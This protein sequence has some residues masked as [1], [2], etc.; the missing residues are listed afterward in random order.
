MNFKLYLKR[1]EHI[2]QLKNKILKYK[3]LIENK[4]D[5]KKDS[6][7]KIKHLD[8][9]IK[10]RREKITA[11]YTALKEDYNLIV[12]Q[13]NEMTKI[14]GI[15]GKTI[16]TIMQDL[17]EHIP[18]N[19]STQNYYYKVVK[20]DISDLKDISVNSEIIAGAILISYVEMQK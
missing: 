15:E 3:K 16:D 12:T 9:R 5:N 8:D 19:L 7:R 17:K 13:D 11:F 1:L 2:E 6:L 14:Q 10:I 18:K 20:S 4:N